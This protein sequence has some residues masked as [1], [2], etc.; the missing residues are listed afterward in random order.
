[1]PQVLS[2]SYLNRVTRFRHIPALDGL[3]AVAVTL[4]ILHHAVGTTRFAGE[5]GVDVFFV[6]SGFLITGLLL[7]EHAAGGVSLRLFYARRAVRLYPALLFMISVV[8]VA[9]VVTG[10]AAHYASHAAIAVTYLSNIDMTVT[11]HYL[12]P[13]SHTWSLA[14]EEQFYLLWPPVLLLLLRRRARPRNVI[15]GLAVVAS[16]S[17][18]GFAVSHPSVTEPSFNPMVRCGGLLAGCALAVAHMHG[19]RFR[20]PALVAAA[21]LT[22]LMIVVVTLSGVP[23]LLPLSVPAATAATL[24][25]VGGVVAAPSSRL[26]QALS[27]PNM[28]YVGRLSYALYLWHYPLLALARGTSL[29]HVI[30]L[31][32]AMAATVAA[33]VVSD[34]WVEAPFRRL[35]HRLRPGNYAAGRGLGPLPGSAA[36][37][38]PDHAAA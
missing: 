30:A 19:L 37:A 12:E 22:L 32:L 8:A 34:R 13:I 9:A 4:V 7:D 11:H 10:Q 36:G 29:P 1:M 21:G 38:L 18:I 5:I 16:A 17:L 28:R 27:T 25:I 2:G 24:L 3:R 23:T 14:M 6:L 35:R 31:P 26:A 33:A 15:V 20:R